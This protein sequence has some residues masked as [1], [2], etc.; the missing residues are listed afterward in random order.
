MTSTPPLLLWLLRKKSI[1]VRIVSR[2]PTI[3]TD[4]TTFSESP[5][6]LLSHAPRHLYV[7]VLLRPAFLL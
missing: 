7:V 4:A 6:L 5:Q 2:S 1:N 3:R